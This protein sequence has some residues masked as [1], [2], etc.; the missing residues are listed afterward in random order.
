ME[1][2]K[3]GADR[4]AAVVCCTEKTKEQRALGMELDEEANSC[5][6]EEKKISVPD[7]KGKEW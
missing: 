3:R 6:G 5:R 2:G 4:Q 7:S 1:K